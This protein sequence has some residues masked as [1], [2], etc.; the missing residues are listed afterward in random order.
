[1][2]SP[3]PPVA[4]QPHMPH[5][6]ACEACTYARA[7]HGAGTGAACPTHGPPRGTWRRPALPGEQSFGTQKMVTAAL[8]RR[9]L[10]FLWLLGSTR[11]TRPPIGRGERNRTLGKPR[12]KRKSKHKQVHKK[13]QSGIVRS[14]G[15]GIAKLLEKK[16]NRFEKNYENCNALPLLCPAT[17]NPCPP[18]RGW[19]WTRGIEIVH[20]R[21][22]PPPRHA[23]RV[24]VLM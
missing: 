3:R 8:L 9:V 20:T 11:E 24:Y 19:S 21:D 1:M 4:P 18:T 22:P 10:Q 16:R 6:R 15:L 23:K 2:T 17:T 13:G 5:M 14:W 12:C 7:S